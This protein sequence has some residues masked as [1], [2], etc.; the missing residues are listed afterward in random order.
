VLKQQGLATIVRVGTY[1][2]EPP[3]AC[4]RI[5][6]RRMILGTTTAAW[7]ARQHLPFHAVRATGDGGNSSHDP[8]VE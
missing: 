3:P 2:P 7:N 5:S 1:G 6:R 8:R 4:A